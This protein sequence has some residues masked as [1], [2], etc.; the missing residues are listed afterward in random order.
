MLFSNFYWWLNNFCKKVDMSL[1]KETKLKYLHPF[2]IHVYRCGW[3]VYFFFLV[4]LCMYK[5]KLIN[6]FSLFQVVVFFCFV[7]FFCFCFFLRCDSPIKN[8]DGGPIHFRNWKKRTFAEK[9][10][11]FSEWITA[12]GPRIAWVSLGFSY[13]QI[14]IFFFFFFFLHAN[15]FDLQKWEPL[16]CNV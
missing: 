11:F 5:K 8:N 2:H 13:N 14:V 15:I 1:N 4:N 3:R 7:F 6:F 9:T 10:L 12:N 16:E